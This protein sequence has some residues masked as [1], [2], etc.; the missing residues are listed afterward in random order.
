MGGLGFYTTAT[1]ALQGADLAGKTAVVT[2]GN[3][4][5]GDH[6]HKGNPLQLFPGISRAEQLGP[7]GLETVRALALAGAH[8]VLLSRSVDA[9]K[10]IAESIRAE[11][12][13]VSSDVVALSLRH[14]VHGL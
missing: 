5:I 3:S 4:G 10:K 14:H 9:G 6:S 12:V 13:L 8:V 2:G 1:Q 11:G 7:A